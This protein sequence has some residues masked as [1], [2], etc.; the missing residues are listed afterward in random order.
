MK[1]GA[2]KHDADR[3][4]NLVKVTW[5][6]WASGT[7][8]LEF[9]LDRDRLRQARRTEGRYLLRTRLTAHEPDAL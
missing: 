8:S 9:N 2:A 7:A 6:K 1:P 3:A 5:P 4:A